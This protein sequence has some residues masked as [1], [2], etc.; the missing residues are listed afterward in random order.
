MC[1]YLAVPQKVKGFSLLAQRL[2]PISEAVQ[3]RLF[4]QNQRKR[5]GLLKQL[6]IL[7]Q[8]SSCLGK[9]QPLFVGSFKAPLMN[10]NK[11]QLVWKLPDFSDVTSH[12][13]NQDL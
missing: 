10:P 2:P 13:Q 1:R 9:I 8:H 11:V 6:L 7:L 4:T 3:I 12:G 5:R